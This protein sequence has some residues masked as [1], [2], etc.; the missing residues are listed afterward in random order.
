MPEPAR[1]PDAIQTM[2]PY[3]RRQEGRVDELDRDWAG[4]R[5]SGERRQSDGILHPGH[6]TGNRAH[7]RDRF[8]GELADRARRQTGPKG[9]LERRSNFEDNRSQ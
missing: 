2:E 3:P 9:R 5:R 4:A 8:P 7:L 6:A 1:N